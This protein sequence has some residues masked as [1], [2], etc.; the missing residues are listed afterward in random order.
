LRCVPL[1]KR[2]LQLPLPRNVRLVANT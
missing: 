1:L 2:K